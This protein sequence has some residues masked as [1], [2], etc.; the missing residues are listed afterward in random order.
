M[1]SLLE[2]LQIFGVNDARDR[3]SSRDPNYGGISGSISRGGPA[4]VF[5]NRVLGMAGVCRFSYA[6]TGE[7][8]CITLEETGVTTTCEL[9]TYDPDEMP[10]IP[11]QKD[12]RL[13]RIIM[14]A[15]SL[16]DAIT[17]L[18][19]TL[20][21][22]ITMVASPTA[23]FLSLTSSG[24]VGSAT[25][26]FSKDPEL[27]ETFYVPERTVNT[28]SYG[29]IRYAS[30]AMSMAKKVS[31]RSDEHGVLS[32][33]FMIDIEGTSVTS[34]VDFRFVA[35]LPEDGEEEVEPNENEV[36]DDTE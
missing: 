24:T 10:D 27:V 15:S 5:D 29:L 34:Y 6:G 23:P 21:S 26:E 18:S 25:V 14:R 16:H 30:R 11:L 1:S 13:Q 22:R 8:F 12:A 3:W 35:F 4:G 32:L 28:Y 17:E 36:E 9:V 2:T 33:Q 7:P 20:P 31:I 19:S